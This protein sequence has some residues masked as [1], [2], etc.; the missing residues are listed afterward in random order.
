MIDLRDPVGRK[1]DY[2][3]VSI[4]DR[5]NL[6]CQYCMP[7]TGVSKKTH[8]AILRYEEIMQIVQVGLGLG[9]KK[10]RIT[11]GEPLIRLGVVE[12]IQM[13]SS[14][15]EL[16]DISMT[17]N[18]LILAKYAA[19]LKEAGLQRINVSLDSLDEE[20]FYQITRRDGW[21]DVWAG[22]QAALEVGLEP[23]KIN[24]VVMRGVNDD[25]IFDFIALTKAYPLHV[26]F[27]EYMPLGLAKL[28]QPERYLPLG[29][30]KQ[31]IERKVKLTPT[32]V[33]HNGPAE[34]YRLHSAQ[35]T[36]G[37]ITPLSHNFCGDCN[38][39]RLTADGKLRPCL[40]KDLEIDLHDQSGHLGDQQFIK[41]RLLE[42]IEKKP[43]EHNFDQP[44]EDR[45]A[46]SMS[47]IGG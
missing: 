19:E 44:R 17:T 13:L 42:A 29:E 4:T 14:L 1:I 22:I 10:V 28:V 16:E 15:T 2:L 6:R 21:T 23:V 8:Q 20:K 43:E 39:L 27:I 34:S 9:I 33:K 7:S 36:V 31:R 46:R 5:C 32:R 26:R 45:S 35:G 30:I 47:Q 18:G 24:V 25:E 38:R 12:F 37:F 11:G 3:R 40:V 41:A